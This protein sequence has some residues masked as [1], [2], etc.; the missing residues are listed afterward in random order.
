[1]KDYQ[2]RGYI[3][4][5]EIWRL[6]E[7]SGYVGVTSK[8]L[9]GR[10]AS[11][12]I[13]AYGRLSVPT[14]FIYPIRLLCEA[15]CYTNSIGLPSIRSFFGV[16]KDI[17]ENYFIGASNDKNTP[18]RFT[19]VGCYFS[20]SS[21]TSDAQNFA[22]AHNIFLVS[23]N[24]IEILNP[25]IDRIGE[26]VKS[27][28]NLKTITKKDLIKEYKLKYAENYNERYDPYVAIGIIDSIYPVTLVGNTNWLE[29]LKD[30]LPNNQDNITYIKT[31]R[32]SNKSDTLFNI[33]IE[34]Q[35]IRFSLPN[36]IAGKLVSRID[37]TV[38]GEKIFEIDIPLII[39]REENL[40]RR[41][42]KLEIKLPDKKSYIREIKSKR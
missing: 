42:A 13:D 29:Y 18:Y 10:G 14:P 33:D 6:L 2:A 31:S 11:H 27:F 19:D 30:A 17:S 7:K 37:K 39:K 15:K 25:I 32:E 8:K 20:S 24:N 40:M 12:Q 1:M 9:K 5:S 23:F 4:E 3:F 26:F 16:I 35:L 38:S 36:I 41:F 34:G 22:W 28:S 21:F